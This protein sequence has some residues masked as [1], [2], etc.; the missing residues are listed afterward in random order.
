MLKVVW[1]RSEEVIC[2]NAGELRSGFAGELCWDQVRFGE[3][4]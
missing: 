1:D 3:I 2:G 4:G